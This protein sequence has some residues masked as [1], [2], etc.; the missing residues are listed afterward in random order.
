MTKILHLIWGMEVG[1]KENFLNQLVRGLDPRQFA[2]TIL[3][4]RQKGPY[5]EQL[6]KD[7]YDVRHLAKD[8]GFDPG[9]IQRLRKEIA[10]IGPDLVHM[11]EFSSTLAARCAVLSAAK[12]GI[13]AA[14]HGGHQKLNFMKKLIYGFLLRRCSAITAVAEHLAEDA[15]RMTRGKV[16]LFRIPYGVDLKRF[17]NTVNRQ[18]KLAELGLPTDARLV[19]CAA[20][21]DPPKLHSLVVRSAAQVCREIPRCH[22]L[23]AGDG[24]LGNSLLRLTARRG[25]KDKVHFIG[26]RT[27]V[28]E[29]L[30]IADVCVL[31]S[32]SEGLPLAIQEYMAAGKP[33]VAT[34]TDGITE[35]VKQGENG[36][37]AGTGDEKEFSA[38]TILLLKE[39][40]MAETMG[41]KGRQIAELQFPISNMLKAY[42]DT[43][44]ST[45]GQSP[46]E[47]RQ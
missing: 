28:P 5:W 26:T 27:D 34:R 44:L 24:T 1:G 38:K 46:A 39:H 45:T 4:L 22:Y 15:R 6:R 47:N 36:F 32:L 16:P 19:V 7:G 20:R 43:Y 12:P 41:Q 33:V 18:A 35:L 10:G 31:A 14:L 40:G 23:L 21:L 3:T 37:L 42:G 11:H 9:A 29:L 8:A 17:G 30:A 13:I 2:N 25:L